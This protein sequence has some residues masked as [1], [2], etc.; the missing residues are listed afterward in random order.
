MSHP[1]TALQ[2]EL[3]SAMLA[4]AHHWMK[5]YAIAHPGA[6]ALDMLRDLAGVLVAVHLAVA[7]GQANAPANKA[8]EARAEDHA[9]TEI[10]RKLT[11]PMTLHA[12]HRTNTA[13]HALEA[14]R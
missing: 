11:R 5:A 2:T 8:A 12:L 1:I 9:D 6:T 4:E 3:E 10:M 13:L 14:K 7:R